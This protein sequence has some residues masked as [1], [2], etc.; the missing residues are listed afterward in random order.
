[1]ANTCLLL[2]GQYSEV[3]PPKQQGPGYAD[4]W[5]ISFK[6]SAMTQ[7]ALIPVLKTSSQ[8][9]NANTIELFILL[10]F[11]LIEPKIPVSKRP[12]P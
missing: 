2:T 1:M 10:R 4:S 6:D 12:I 7:L 9:I 5:D 8:I 11:L 3:S